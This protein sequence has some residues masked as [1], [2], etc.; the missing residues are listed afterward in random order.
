MLTSQPAWNTLATPISFYATAF[1]LGVLA[2][3]A[4]FVANY[5]YMQRKQ[6]G[7]ADEQCTLMRETLRWIAL[8]AMILLGVELVV[9]P[10]YLV[11]VASASTA[12]YA[13]IKLMSG[14]LGWL[15]ILRVA[16]VFLGAGVFGLFLYQNAMSAGKEKVIGNIAYLAFIVVLASEVLGRVL[17]YISHIRVGI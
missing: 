11:S 3:G 6:P 7:C 2:M 1:L 5:S 13:T 15:L 9:L 14:S 16:L 8:A 17:F 12:G 4:A 10:V